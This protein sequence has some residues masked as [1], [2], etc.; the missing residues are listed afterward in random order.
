MPDDY[1]FDKK[2]QNCQEEMTLLHESGRIWSCGMKC[3]YWCP[4]CGTILQWYDSLPIE[5]NDWTF[6][7]TLYRAHLNSLRKMI[8]NG[9]EYKKGQE[10]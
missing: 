4:K 7:T 8:E 10:G 6:P 9:N 3:I 5:S 1:K 2:C